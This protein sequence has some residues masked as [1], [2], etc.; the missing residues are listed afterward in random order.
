MQI[1][2]RQKTRIIHFDAR[3]KKTEY[4]KWLPWNGWPIMHI[5]LIH[6]PIVNKVLAIGKE[7]LAFHCGLGYFF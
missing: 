1:F 2:K 7:L 6:T 5:M 4:G 3:L